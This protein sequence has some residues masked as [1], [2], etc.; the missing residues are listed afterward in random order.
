VITA[1]PRPFVTAATYRTETGEVLQLINAGKFL[2]PDGTIS[3]D[4]MPDSLHLAPKGYEIWSEAI[5]DKLKELLGDAHSG[6]TP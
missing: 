2:E 3:K 5:K 4:V 6:K 1:V